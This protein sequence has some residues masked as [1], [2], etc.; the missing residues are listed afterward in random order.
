MMVQWSALSPATLTKRVQIL[1]AINFSELL[2]E[3][4]KINQKE[5]GAGPLKNSSYKSR[6]FFNAPSHSFF[7][8]PS[9]HSA[10][11]LVPGGS[12]GSFPFLTWGHIFLLEI[13]FFVRSNNYK[14]TGKKHWIGKVE[15]C[16]KLPGF[17][18][19]GK[20]ESVSPVSE[21]LRSK[22]PRFEFRWPAIENWTSIIELQISCRNI[23]VTRP[24][25]DPIKISA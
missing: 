9:S 13:S 17:V 8:C 2:N 20:L 16:F 4:I 14:G 11:I 24:G 7:F 22:G 25:P 6:H 15:I 5:A 1:L 3:K 23:R 18:F 12:G 21:S 19:R 10:K